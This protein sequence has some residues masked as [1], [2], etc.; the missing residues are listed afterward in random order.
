[1][2]AVLSLLRAAALAL[3]AAGSAAASGAEGPKPNRL[4]DSGSPYLLQ[5]AHNPVDW[6][7]WGAEAIEKARREGKPIFISVGYSTCYWCHVANRSLYQDP[8]IAALMNE[9]FISI[10]IDREQRPDLDRLFMAVTGALTGR[11]GWPNNL[12]L[13]PDLE[14]FYA[15]SYFPPTDDEFGRPGFVTVLKGIR[16]EWRL[17]RG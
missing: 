1:M 5:H 9:G 14:P 11:G 15:G 13:T 6:H 7:P 8:A 10:K 4:I 16:E 2:H 17:R 12:F 3:L